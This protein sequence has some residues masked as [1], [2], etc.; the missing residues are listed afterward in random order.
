M[1]LGFTSLAF[2]LFVNFLKWRYPPTPEREARLGYRVWRAV[3]TFATL[4]VVAAAALAAWLMDRHDQGIPTVGKIEPGL[5]HAVFPSWSRL[6]LQTTAMVTQAL[7]LALLGTYVWDELVGVDTKYI[8]Y[9]AHFFILLSNSLYGDVLG[10]QKVCGGE[11]RGAGPGANN[12]T[13]NQHMLCLIP[14][15]V[16]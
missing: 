11:S 12:Q 13:P 7:P 1:A 9:C 15:V 10:R 5:S 6:D 4:V 3:A 2:L 14:L 8:S 16:T